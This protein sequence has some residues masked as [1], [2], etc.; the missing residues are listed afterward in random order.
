MLTR[1]RGAV[2]DRLRKQAKTRA[3]KVLREAIGT[4]HAGITQHMLRGH[5]GA[6][7]PAHRLQDFLASRTHPLDGDPK[8][9][10]VV[11]AARNKGCSVPCS[12]RKRPT[13]SPPPLHDSCPLP[14]D[15]ASSSSS[16]APPLSPVSKANASR[17]LGGGNRRGGASSASHLHRNMLDRALHKKARVLDPMS[18]PLLPGA[19]H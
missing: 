8:N 6:M 15:A 13:D 16:P 5:C 18:V 19:A 7:Q 14:P 17:A 10:C 1:G 11:F 3:V 9:K 2:A 4:K 12:P